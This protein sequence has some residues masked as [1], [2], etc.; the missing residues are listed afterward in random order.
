MTRKSK[1]RSKIETTMHEF[2]H[3]G[4]HSGSKRGPKVR[5]RKQA[6]AIALSQARKAGAR[7]PKRKGKSR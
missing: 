7:I 6:I 5:D 2:K 3:G 4:L 1:G